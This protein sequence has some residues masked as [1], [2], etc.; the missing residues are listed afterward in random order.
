MKLF[1]VTR[2]LFLSLAVA[3]LAIPV[4]AQD[5]GTAELKAGSGKISIDYGRPPLKGRDPLTWQKDGTFW[6]MGMNATTKITT[7]I[8]LVFGSTKLPKGTY[9]LWLQKVSADQYKLVF[10]SDVP[11]MGMSHSDAKDVA[12]VTLKKEAIPSPVELFT[13]EL[14]EAPKGGAFSMI[15]ASVKLS[16]D[17]EFGK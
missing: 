3:A 1:K 16:T 12:A 9:S 11:D 4:F 5:R 15:W 2:W 7:P 8:D 6:R 14:K 10:N 13:L 17:F